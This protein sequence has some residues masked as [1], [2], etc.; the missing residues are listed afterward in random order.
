MSLADGKIAQAAAC[1]VR[2]NAE[3]F[4]HLDSSRL[5]ISAIAPFFP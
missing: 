2:K 5:S 3:S 1:I 4:P